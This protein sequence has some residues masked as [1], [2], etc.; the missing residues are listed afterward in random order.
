MFTPGGD[1]AIQCVAARHVLQDLSADLHV[2]NVTAVDRDSTSRINYEVRAEEALYLSSTYLSISYF[3][4]FLFFFSFLFLS[5]FL[6][7]FLLLFSFSFSRL[8][9][10]MA[11]HILS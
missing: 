8:L 2:G 5:S 9:R 11:V 7:F 4:C 10:A 6:S 1:L 3:F